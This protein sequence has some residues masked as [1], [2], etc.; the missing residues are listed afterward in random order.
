[1]KYESK[2]LPYTGTQN[3]THRTKLPVTHFEAKMRK[4]THK[5]SNNFKETSY[6]VNDT[7]TRRRSASQ[8]YR[9]IFYQTA[10]IN[11]SV[12]FRM[13]V[14]QKYSTNR[15]NERGNWLSTVTVEQPLCQV[16]R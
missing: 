13:L 5:L 10:F 12:L 4:K 15:L 6:E 7:V 3:M 2:H 14:F 9:S 16:K 8:C 11:I 1:M